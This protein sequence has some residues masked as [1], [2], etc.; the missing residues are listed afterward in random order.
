MTDDKQRLDMALQSGMSVPHLSGV[1]KLSAQL[2]PH[3]G[4]CSI[5]LLHVSLQSSL[6]HLKLGPREGEG[7]AEVHPSGL[8]VHGHQLQCPDAP[9]PD[10]LKETLQSG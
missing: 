10:R 7:A 4:G 1:Q 6:H 3:A 9:A 2:A 5:L 8:H